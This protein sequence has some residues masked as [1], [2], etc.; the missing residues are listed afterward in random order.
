MAKETM[1]QTQKVSG[2]VVDKDNVPIIGATV[3]VELSLIHI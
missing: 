1:Q 3:V 2:T